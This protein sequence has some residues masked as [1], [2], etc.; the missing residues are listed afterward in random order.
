MKSLETLTVVDLIQ[1]L[2][3]VSE[4]YQI[5]ANDAGMEYGGEYEYA[6]WMKLKEKLDSAIERL[7]DVN[8]LWIDQIPVHF[9][10]C[11]VRNQTPLFDLPVI[12]DALE[13]YYDLQSEEFQKVKK[14]MELVRYVTKYLERSEQYV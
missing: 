14:Q 5:R 10:L 7:K 1:I 6:E 12:K 4:Q 11:K 3:Y 2:Q 8:N 9:Q 13:F